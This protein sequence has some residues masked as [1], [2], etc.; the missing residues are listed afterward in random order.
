MDSRQF[1]LFLKKQGIVRV[2]CQLFSRHNKWVIVTAFNLNVDHVVDNLAGTEPITCMQHQTTATLNVGRD[3]IQIRKPIGTGLSELCS[4]PISKLNFSGLT[5]AQS[6]TDIE[7]SSK[8]N[9]T[10]EHNHSCC[11]GNCRTRPSQCLN[12]RSDHL[13]CPEITHRSSTSF[14][15]PWACSVAARTLTEKYT[16]S[17]PRLSTKRRKHIPSTPQLLLTDTA[18]PLYPHPPRHLACVS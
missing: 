14:L 12:S 15:G 13:I 8:D 1:I 6:C 18:I 16:Q 4:C 11:L 5:F 17:W 9:H 7:S 2:Q 10:A 3:C